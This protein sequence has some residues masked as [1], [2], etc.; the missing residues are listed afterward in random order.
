MSSSELRVI[1]VA[2]NAGDLL[3]RSVASAVDQAGA[4][5]VTIVDSGSSDGASEYVARAYDGVSLIR[6]ANRGFA[7]ANNVVLQDLGTTF[8]LLLNPDAILEPG[9]LAV[10][11]AC[12]ETHPRA[13]IVG[14]HTMDPDGGIQAGSYGRFPTLLRLLALRAQR[15]RRRLSGGDGSGLPE[16]D[17]CTSVDWT[18]G[19]CMLVRA[20][21]I[22][23]AGLMDEGYFLYFEDVDWCH[24]MRDA[25]W[26]VLVEPA[27]RVVHYLGRSGAASAVVAQ[28]Y[29]DSF[30]RYIEKYGLRGLGA[31]ARVGLAVR[32]AFGGRS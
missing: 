12:A 11:V 18:T 8:A 24:R 5:S 32:R 9:A 20:R 3:A 15:F 14:P 13:A 6:V 10:L 1:V 29:R 4:D 25:G 23:E 28:A 2:H 17:R 26:D 31:V 30:Y 22:E 27:A 7:A 19:A 16:F 21:A